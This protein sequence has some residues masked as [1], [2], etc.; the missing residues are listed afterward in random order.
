M[1]VA[2]INAT[3]KPRLEACD[4]RGMPSGDLISAVRGVKRAQAR[5]EKAREELH[6]AIVK[7]IRDEGWKQRDVVEVTGYSRE[8][9]RRI[10]EAAG[11]GP[12]R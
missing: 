6:E 4:D 12:L 2:F 9:V 1:N 5:L 11:V 8:H 7:A 3:S 10:C